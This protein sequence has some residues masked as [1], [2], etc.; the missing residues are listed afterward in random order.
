MR[1]GNQIPPRPGMVW[2]Q[3]HNRWIEPDT[4]RPERQKRDEMVLRAIESDEERIRELIRVA[5]E[6]RG[7]PPTDFDKATRRIAAELVGSLITAR[8]KAGLSQAEVARR[9]GVPQPAVVRLE[10]GTHSP[11]LSTLARYAKAIGVDV[12][13]VP[14]SRPQ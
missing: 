11:T 4:R 3:K 8:E 5:N 6:S 10:T 12:Q 1:N 14:A 13:V 7:K 2:S 9:M